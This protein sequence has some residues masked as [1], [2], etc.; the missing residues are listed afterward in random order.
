RHGTARDVKIEMEPEPLTYVL[1]AVSSESRKLALVGLSG[2]MYK[3]LT[4]AHISRTVFTISDLP[5]AGG[6][7]R[8]VNKFGYKRPLS[9]VVQILRSS[10]PAMAVIAAHRRK[11][12]VVRTP[13]VSSTNVFI[14]SA[15][16]FS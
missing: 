1:T 13:C 6:P 14:Q 7:V 16:N 5:L 2:P 10:T 9:V 15:M 4:F 8:T 3:P 12:G 11:L